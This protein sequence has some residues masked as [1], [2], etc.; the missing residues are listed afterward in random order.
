MHPTTT[1]SMKFNSLL[2]TTVATVSVL[3]LTSLTKNPIARVDGASLDADFEADFELD[4]GDFATDETNNREKRVPT[5]HKRKHKW[6]AL[7][8]KTIHSHL[9]GVQEEEREFLEEGSVNCFDDDGNEVGFFCLMRPNRNVEG[10]DTLK[11]NVNADLCHSRVDRDQVHCHGS[12]QNHLYRHVIVDHMNRGYN[13]RLSCQCNW[14]PRGYASDCDITSD[15]DSDRFDNGKDGVCPKEDAIKRIA[16]Q[17]WGAVKWGNL[18]I[19][20][21]ESVGSTTCEDFE[22]FQDFVE[23]LGLG[24]G[25]GSRTDDGTAKFASIQ[26][27]GCVPTVKHIPTK[28]GQGC[29]TETTYCNKLKSTMTNNIPCP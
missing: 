4:F 7:T 20:T 28:D 18:H 6:N 13:G 24:D 2:K 15:D 29:I 27:G 14:P 17:S 8:E 23:E 5:F 9:F 1:S 16:N 26:R 12:P 10:G 22:K 11:E 21:D 19:C 25:T 3:A